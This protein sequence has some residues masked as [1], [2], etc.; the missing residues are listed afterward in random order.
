LKKNKDGGGEPLK[1][2]YRRKEKNREEPL[3]NEGTTVG[4]RFK[5]V[6]LF[7]KMEIKKKMETQ[8]GGSDKE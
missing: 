3:A 8:R 2:G 6:I 1:R 4:P 5:R 7:V